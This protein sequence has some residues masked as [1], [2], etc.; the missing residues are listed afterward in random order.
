MP[1]C[2]RWAI[3]GAVSCQGDKCDGGG[4]VLNM[5]KS[6]HRTITEVETTTSGNVCRIRLGNILR[7]IDSFVIFFSTPSR[8][9]K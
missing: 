6:L 2:V 8:L 5:S 7:L 3:A 9:L 4:T 1:Y